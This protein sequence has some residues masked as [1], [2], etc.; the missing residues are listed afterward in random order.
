MI[1]LSS[2]D[3]IQAVAGTATAVTSTISG[4][5]I[6]AGVDTFK[7]LDQR[8]LPI[9]AG[10]LYTPGGGKTALV[11][12]WQLSNTT[13]SPVNITLYLN[14]T[15]AANQIASFPLPANGE[16]ALGD[17]G[18]KIYDANG[19]LLT[20]A[21]LSN[22]F[23]TNVSL[24]QMAA[25]TYK[26]N[27][28]A[29]TANAADI[30][31]AQ[32]TAD[33]ALATTSSQGMMSAS[34]KKQMDN[35][36]YDIVADGGADPTGVAD[37][38]AVIQTAINTVAAAGGGIVFIPI[39]TYKVSTTITITGNFVT[40]RGAS[41][42][43]SKL[44]PNFATG[45]IF[46]VSGIFNRFEYLRIEPASDSLRTSGYAIEFT[47]TA[48]NCGCQWV[49]ILFM[50]S[51]IKASGQLCRLEDM[52]VRE[53]GY[54]A[55]NGQMVLIDTFTDQYLN[56]LVFDNDPLKVDSGFA[57]V[58]ITNLSS[59][60]MTDCQVIHTMI[61][62][63][64]AP[65]GTNTIPSIFC[66]NTFFD[67]GTI[68]ANFAGAAG[69]FIY[70]CKFTQ[71]WF[72]SQ[73]TAGVVLNKSTLSG[74]DFI[75]CDFYG[76]PFGIDA[77]AAADW[78]V[79]N[80]RFAGNTTNAIRTTAGAAHSFTVAGCFIGNGSGFGANGQGINIQAGTY[81]SYQILDNRGLA[82]N[83]TP[84]IIDLGTVATG[85]QKN[86]SNNVGA[87]VAGGA[88]SITANVTLTT[89]PGTVIASAPI[90]ANA[91]RAGDT[92]RIVAHGQT[93]VAG[94]VTFRLHYGAAGTTAD[95]PLFTTPAAVAATT[96]LA[97]LTFD[98]TVTVRA[99]GASGS[100]LANGVVQ[101]LPLT[102]GAATGLSARTT[103]T[104]AVSV[105]TTSAKFLTISAFQS[106]G[107]HTIYNAMIA[108]V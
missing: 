75:S 63:D 94:T 40:V 93:S 108:V 50:W 16:A 86:T 29:S 33:L 45:N 38:T 54:N 103:Q 24:A 9:S 20:T 71:C 22:N 80:S 91:L 39:G 23:V 101:A 3:S 17:E 7:V 32:L 70:R 96:T 104:A 15:A 87:L 47:S 25:H 82:T 27:N 26:G 65:T 11:K 10:S 68:G 79:R 19:A 77:Q 49:D 13:G 56:K 72:S 67:N 88:T 14:G 76:S 51:G 52:N 73:S 60:I 28:T 48:S 36:Y 78:S 81:K 43:A 62:L 95:T 61:G 1:T 37:A 99:I 74:V 6:N 107:T 46:T 44:I 92:F 8:Q 90:P 106:A 102:T 66:A 58:R 12:Q 53:C 35:M 69:A 55:I 97:G 57:G 100:I 31:S 64:V 98:A 84:G 83:T 89:T 18:W 2:S 5:E 4:D 21:S 42:V 59:L 41:R 34:D 30:T 105:D 85:D